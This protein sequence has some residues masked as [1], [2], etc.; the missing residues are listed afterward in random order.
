MSS[1]ASRAVREASLIS[2]DNQRRSEGV[3]RKIYTPRTLYIFNSLALHVASTCCSELKSGEIRVYIVSEFSILISAN[4]PRIDFRSRSSRDKL[5]KTNL[6]LLFY[7]MAPY[8]KRWRRHTTG[9][10]YFSVDG[11]SKVHDISRLSYILFIPATGDFQ[12]CSRREPSAG[13]N[14]GRAM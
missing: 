12:S 13:R 2:L 6:R 3:G 9:M 11:V 8:L 10:G 5:E 1:N 14:R 7:L 4:I